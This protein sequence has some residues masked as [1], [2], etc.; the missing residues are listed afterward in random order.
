MGATTLIDLLGARAREHS[1]RPF[2]RFADGDVSFGQADERTARM[3]GGLRE[4]GVMPGELVAVMLPNC[5][6][7]ALTWLA[8]AK[9]GA[10]EA[11]VN[12][13]FRG[14]GLAHVLNLTRARVLIADE[15]YLAAIADV[16]DELMHVTTL[17]VR[18]DAEAAGA[19]VP[20]AVLPFGR[21][22]SDGP[23]IPPAAVGPN[24]LAM[25]LF[26]SGTTGRSKGCM[27]SHRYLVR[28]AELFCEHLELRHDDVL[29]CPF[30]LFHADAT[31][32]TVAAGA[33]ARRHGGDRRALLGVAASGTRCARFGATVFDFMG[34]TLTMLHKQ[35]PRPD[36]RDNPVRLAWGVPVP[37]VRCRVR[38]ALRLRLVEVY[39]LTDAG[40]VDLPPP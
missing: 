7:F 25:L 30:P 12:T 2:L 8:L 22:E 14:P 29:Y 24:D 10:V 40:I 5:S 34:A 26:T 11:P 21:L 33:G 36:D 27:L 1:G 17:V 9:A 16:W 20:T 15:R 37:G 4:L 19:R 28:Q 18:G 23:P 38:G 32:F 13:A 3:A 31:V 35:P 39:G 6:D